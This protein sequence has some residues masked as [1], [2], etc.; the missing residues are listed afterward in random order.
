[1][2][3]NH[4]TSA[5]LRG[6]RQVPNWYK[7]GGRQNPYALE[8][9]SQTSGNEYYIVP[10]SLTGGV[11]LQGF[12]ISMWVKV[13]GTL[14][15]QNYGL[16]GMLGS[17]VA[18]YTIYINGITNEIQLHHTVQGVVS[19][20]SYT[21]GVWCNITIVDDGATVI[22]FK[23]GVAGTGTGVSAPSVPLTGYTLGAADIPFFG[24]LLYLD[25][26]VVDELAFFDNAQDPVVLYNNGI[27]LSFDSAHAGLIATY[28]VEKP[29]GA[30]HNRAIPPTVIGPSAIGG[31]APDFSWNGAGV[32]TK[33]S[34]VTSGLRSN[35]TN[36]LI[37][38]ADNYGDYGRGVQASRRDNRTPLGSGN[39]LESLANGLMPFPAGG[40]FD[41]TGYTNAFIGSHDEPNLSPQVSKT[42]T[43]STGDSTVY[44]AQGGPNTLSGKTDARSGKLFPPTFVKK[45]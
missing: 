14:L 26:C 11:S 8:W 43:M 9:T 7:W 21:T 34:V 17:S 25:K 4:H 12:T 29:V 37:Q 45:S 27:P 20:A 1:M 28:E 39:S 22:M 6:C 32:N 5:L 13:T 35:D 42:I 44:A 40:G 2:P 41:T 3:R 31:S 18:T 24:G 16:F 33:V 38:M 36:A 15:A 30:I 19:S 10:A 23:N